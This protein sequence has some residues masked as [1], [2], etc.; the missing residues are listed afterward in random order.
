MNQFYEKEQ[1]VQLQVSIYSLVML[2]FDRSTNNL[3]VEMSSIRQNY[4][5][6]YSLSS[7][8]NNFNI[9]SSNY[10][11]S[12]NRYKNVNIDQNYQR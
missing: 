11:K 9:S 5:N 6:K 1:L 2:Y 3:K 10:K 7:I 12:C 4:S 8:L